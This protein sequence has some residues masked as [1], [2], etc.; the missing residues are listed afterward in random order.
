ME[1]SDCCD[2]LV[3]NC[4][5]FDKAK[6][7]EDPSG[8]LRPEIVEEV[9]EKYATV[10]LKAVTNIQKEHAKSIQDE[11]K[12]LQKS[13]QA[14]IEIYANS[15]RVNFSFKHK[16]SRYNNFWPTYLCSV[17][18]QNIGTYFS[19]F[20]LFF[21]ITKPRETIEVEETLLIRMCAVHRLP[22]E[23]NYDEYKISLQVYHGSRPIAEPLH[24]IF[25]TQTKS[26]YDRI[27]FDSWLESKLTKIFVLPRESRIVLTLFSRHMVTED[28]ETKFVHTELGWSSLQLFNYDGFL[29]QGTFLLNLWPIE[30]EKQ[31]GP[32]PDNGSHPNADTCPLLRYF[33]K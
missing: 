21:S 23:W 7:N 16:T 32:A 5:A 15:F 4:M 22:P 9:G 24:T 33:Q 18:F 27:V 17:N 20:F 8:K 10:V 30:A 25:Q 14:L 3:R 26:F 2:K 19:H 13:V 6:G 29:V 28:K 1:I 31:V 12:N 11:L